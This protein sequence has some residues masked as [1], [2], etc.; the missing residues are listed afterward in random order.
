[1]KS[2]KPKTKRGPAKGQGGRPPGPKRVNLGTV[3]V[4]EAT[5]AWLEARG[6]TAAQAL[7]DLSGSN[8][9]GEKPRTE[10]A[11]FSSDL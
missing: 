10:S 4:L 2:A 5:A 3:R 9:S 7:D 6:Q 8:E 1:M 11:D